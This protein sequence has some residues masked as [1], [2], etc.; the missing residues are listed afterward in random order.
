MTS[1]GSQSLAAPEERVSQ[2]LLEAALTLG[3]S[4]R[5]IVGAGIAWDA[6]GALAA[7][8]ARQSLS[9][10]ELC[11]PSCQW[12]ARCLCSHCC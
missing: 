12:I 1:L 5:T 4:Q 6:A 10:G 8:L 3:D 9:D 7:I 11:T 2:L